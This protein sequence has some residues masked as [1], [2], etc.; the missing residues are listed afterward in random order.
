MRIIHPSSLGGFAE[1]GS[2]ARSGNAAQSTA[3]IVIDFV[4]VGTCCGR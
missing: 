2:T 4:M 3:Q 1:A